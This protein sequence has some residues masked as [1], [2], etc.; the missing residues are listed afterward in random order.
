MATAATMR[1]RFAGQLVIDETLR[2]QLGVAPRTSVQRF[3]GSCPLS[4]DA[5]PWYLGAVGE[6]AVGDILER[7]PE[8][9]SARHA[10]P[11]RTKESD[12]D[13]VVVG[14]G[15]VFTINTKHHAGKSIWVAGRTMLVDGQRQQYIRN[16]EG[17]SARLARLLGERMPHHVPVHPLIVVVDPKR[18]MVKVRPERVR[19]LNSHEV[20]RWLKQ[21][22]ETLSSDA[23]SD[24]L[25]V[26]DDPTLW[27]ATDTGDP[28]EARRQ[29]AELHDQVRAARCRRR[30][31]AFAGMAALLA[32]AIGAL[33]QLPTLFPLVFGAL[34]G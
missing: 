17:E 12:I 13:H 26:I 33:A 15:G 30:L 1:D 10:L 25:T 27:R 4:D 19:V 21:Q 23:V 34:A 14:P 29:F 8:G 28:A 22:P 11:V 5:R 7:L 6:I 24:L 3:F 20:R 9:W 32:L 31:W 18:I 16:A 2:R